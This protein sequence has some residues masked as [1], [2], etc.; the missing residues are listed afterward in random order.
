MPF[1]DD[2]IAEI[3]L[4]EY[5]NYS[6]G[7]TRVVT[8]E[9]TAI[10]NIARALNQTIARRFETGEEPGAFAGVGGNG[11]FCTLT[12]QDGSKWSI[13]PRGM[14]TITSQS[15]VA[16]DVL[17]LFMDHE[18]VFGLL[19]S[20]D[21]V[22]RLQPDISGVK[23]TV[24][25]KAYQ[26]ANTSKSQTHVTPVAMFFDSDPVLP[27]SDTHTC[28]LQWS[29]NSVPTTVT[30]T[31]YQETQDPVNP[32]D[33]GTPLQV[34]GTD[35]P[36]PGGEGKQ[37]V[38]VRAEFP[39]GVWAE[40]IFSY[41]SSIFPTAFYDIEYGNNEG[42]VTLT[43]T[44]SGVSVTGTQ[45]RKYVDFV[46]S[47]DLTPSTGA[48]QS[49][50]VRK[51]FAMEFLCDGEAYNFAFTEQGLNFNGQA[52]NVGNTQVIEELYSFDIKDP[53][54]F[55]RVNYNLRG[56]LTKDVAFFTD[57]F[58]FAAAGVEKFSIIKEEPEQRIV[59][60]ID[61]ISPD[62]IT[63]ILG[64]VVL[65][66]DWR[67]DDYYNLRR[68]YFSYEV[69]LKDGTVYTIGERI[70]KNGQDTGWYTIQSDSP[71]AARLIEGQS[72][73][74]QRRDKRISGGIAMDDEGNIIIE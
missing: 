1:T 62:E 13:N 70:L 56:F 60:D 36:L 24:Y 5:E 41:R 58:P 18:A 34:K 29:D 4:E 10:S 46:L 30:A 68:F 31:L 27:P 20:N 57:Q 37:F 52:Y 74:E 49:L 53:N 44:D 42:G 26:S 16:E 22:P 14:T 21:S 61:G 54:I 12:M 51:P 25:E 19:A 23:P 35:L 69:T 64:Y 50:P 8:T 67:E 43:R 59:Y 17:T 48:A 38:V 63:E 2:D 47:L 65:G 9:R 7:V 32:V 55:E 3:L 39:G 11:Y 72:G 15:G 45:N 40:H 66:K 71:V 33:T 28:R 73:I 6:D